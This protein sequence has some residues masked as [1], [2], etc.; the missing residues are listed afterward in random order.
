[1]TVRAVDSTI[2]LQDDFFQSIN[3]TTL[4]NRALKENEASWNGFTELQN[5]VTK[6]LNSLIDE[7]VEEKDKYAQ[8]SIEQK[9]IDFYLLARDMDK[10]NKDGIEPLKPYLD[11]LDK[12]STVAELVDVLAELARYGI[13][14]ILNFGVLQD[15]MDSSRYVL[16]NQGPGYTLPNI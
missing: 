13:G 10:R 11:K 15:T 1:M 2:R 12:A 6:D 4:S 8:G 14:S 3:A 9:I 16:V 5:Q 7:L